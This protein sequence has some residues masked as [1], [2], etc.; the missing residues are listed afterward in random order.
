MVLD[1]DE[2]YHDILK[3]LDVFSTELSDIKVSMDISY[4]NNNSLDVSLEKINELI[5]DNGFSEIK[6]K[7]ESFRRFKIK[8]KYNIVD[9][10]DIYEKNN[11]TINSSIS[12]C[13]DNIVVCF[14]HLYEQIITSAYF[15]M[16]NYTKLHYEYMKNIDKEYVDKNLKYYSKIQKL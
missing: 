16:I 7:K 6:N 1:I 9:K 3:L 14:E 8:N 4:S 11:K 2:K 15:Y 13:I 10:I 12:V 5:L